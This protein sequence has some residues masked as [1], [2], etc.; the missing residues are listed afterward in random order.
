MTTPVLFAL[1]AAAGTIGRWQA[2]RL[3]TATWATGTLVVNVVACLGA[4]LVAGRSA[5]TVTLSAV[6]M[7][8]SLSTFSTVVRELTE[9]AAQ[10][11]GLR[12]AGGYACATLAAGVAAA[13]VGL[14]LG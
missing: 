4:G 5:T 2:A 7:L 10:P 8:G 1:L 3:N 13:W 6:A 9:T 14:R 12:R 11:S